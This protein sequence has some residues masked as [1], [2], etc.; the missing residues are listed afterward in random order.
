MLVS[1]ADQRQQRFDW[2]DLA[3]P[4][5]A[6]DPR[7]VPERCQALD[8]QNERA[9]ID[10]A[11]PRDNA[12]KHVGMLRHV[13]HEARRPGFERLDH[14]TDDRDRGRA[15]LLAFVAGDAMEDAA[16]PER[17]RNLVGIV[18]RIE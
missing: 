4:E 17:A 10:A 5:Q 11:A 18:A 9:W 1:A 14:P 13:R 12:A 6:K 8:T 3:A 2:I 15:D 16:L 7:Q